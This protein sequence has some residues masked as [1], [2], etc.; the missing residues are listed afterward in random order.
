LTTSEAYEFQDH[1][2]LRGIDADVGAEAAHDI[3]AEFGEHRRWHREVSCCFESGTLIL[4]GTNDFD[5]NGLA[6]LDEFG[7][8]LSAYLKDHGAVRVVSVETV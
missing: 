6:L 3:Q 5:R 1:A 2:C 8:C 4:C 7:D